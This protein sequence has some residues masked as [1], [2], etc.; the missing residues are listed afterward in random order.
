MQDWS[1]G[2]EPKSHGTFYMGLK[3]PCDIIIQGPIGV[4]L[5]YIF[6]CFSIRQE[7]SSRFR[8]SLSFTISSEE[9]QKIN[10]FGEEPEIT[11]P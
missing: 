6:F 11:K 8:E 3:S 10:F 1:I 5:L 7:L 9:D 4:F 2:D